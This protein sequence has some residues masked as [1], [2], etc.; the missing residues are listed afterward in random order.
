MHTLKRAITALL[1]LLLA[2]VVLFFVLE[3]QQ[4]V[5]LVIF[6]WSS[7]QLPLAVPVLA[8]LIIGLAVGPLLG[9]YGVLRSRRRIRA[10][11]REAALAGK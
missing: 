4:G 1:L 9:A 6:G 10:S 7:P 2:A 8:A 5:S 11:A 3:N